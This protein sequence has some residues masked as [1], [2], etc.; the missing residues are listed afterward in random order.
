MEVPKKKKWLDAKSE[1]I[2]IIIMACC[3]HN[4]CKTFRV[5]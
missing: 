4:V 5:A 2:P 1:N 3:V